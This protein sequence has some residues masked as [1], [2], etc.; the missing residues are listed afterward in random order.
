MKDT[1]KKLVLEKLLKATG[2]LETTKL[3]TTGQGLERYL[4]SL[5]CLG[6]GKHKAS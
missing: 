2:P 4:A 3:T 1:D 6:N 5:Q